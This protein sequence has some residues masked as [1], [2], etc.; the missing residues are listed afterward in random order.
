MV[1]FL[2]VSFVNVYVMRKEVRER[3]VRSFVCVCM[4]V[5]MYGVY[6]MRERVSD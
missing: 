2:V 6:V 4:C 1:F 5:C 3:E